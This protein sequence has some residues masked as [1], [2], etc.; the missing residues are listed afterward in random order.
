MSTK[1]SNARKTSPLPTRIW[2]FGARFASRED[3]R[4]A[5]D[6]LYLAS[7]YYNRMVEIE[8]DRVERFRVIRAKYAPELAAA[9]ARWLELDG[10]ISQIYR[11]TR[12]SRQSSRSASTP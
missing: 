2:K 5:A 9:D 10:Q 6:I 12:D 3:E 11:E 8:R 7:R 4:R 1:K